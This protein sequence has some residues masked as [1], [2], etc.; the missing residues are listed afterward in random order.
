MVDYP[1]F[2]GWGGAE[3]GRFAVKRIFAAANA[4]IAISVGIIVLLGYFIDFPAVSGFRFILLRWAIILAGVA[5]LVGIG[6]LFSVHFQKFR[7][8]RAGSI[9]SFVLLVFLLLTAT[10][11]ISPILQP[12]Q[13]VLVNGIMV[14]VEIS[15]MAV[16]AVTLIYASLRLLKVRGDLASI[17][18][19][20]TALLIMLGTAPLPLIGQLPILSDWLRPLISNVLAT[21][22][23][24]GILIGVALGTLTTGLRILF[25]VDRPYGGK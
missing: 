4:V 16:L 15:L 6:N 7:E 23:A 5:V 11:S 17:L 2:V 21:G 12:L 1:G 9:N 13:R 8:R 10:V 20:V 3:T 22:G 18:F 19:L 25:G 24:R 14:P